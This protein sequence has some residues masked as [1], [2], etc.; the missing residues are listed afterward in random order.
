MYILFELDVLWEI[1]CLVFSF[2]H[3]SKYSTKIISSQHPARASLFVSKKEIEIRI[4]I[5]T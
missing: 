4:A 5:N 3:P 2:V 1:I